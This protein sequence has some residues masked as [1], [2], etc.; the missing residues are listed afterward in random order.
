[1]STLKNL[2]YRLINLMDARP[3]IRYSIAR[4][5]GDADFENFTAEIVGMRTHKGATTVVYP[6]F[7]AKI[8]K[9][10]IG[11]SSTI[12]NRCFTRSDNK[13]LGDEVVDRILKPWEIAGSERDRAEEPWKLES[14]G[15][16]VCSLPFAVVHTIGQERRIITKPTNL[17]LVPYH[18]LV[19]MGI[20]HLKM[21]ELHSHHQ[22]PE[23][24]LPL[25]LLGERFDIFAAKARIDSA[26]DLFALS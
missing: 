16:W 8:G 14:Q 17:H 25:K 18:F 2:A 24:Y 3:V 1:M 11:V 22:T 19:A 6:R 10:G 5:D 26:K 9:E 13:Y 4:P 12:D 15:M 20:R 7:T 21:S 23:S